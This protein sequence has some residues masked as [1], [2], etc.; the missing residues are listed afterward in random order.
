M[1]EYNIFSCATPNFFPFVNSVACSLKKYKK[2][3]CKYVYHIFLTTENV[4][5]YK[6][7]LNHLI[8]DDFEIKIKSTKG[9][10]EKIISPNQNLHWSTYFRCFV[11]SL[12]PNLDKILYLDVDLVIINKGLEDFM[13]VDLTNYYGA[14]I[15]DIVQMYKNKNQL[16][17]TKTNNYFNAGVL[18]FNLQKIRQEG[19]NKRMEDAVT[20]NWPFEEVQPSAYD[21][22]LLNYLFRDR[23]KLINPKFNNNFHCSLLEELEYFKIQYGKWG[24]SDLL[25]SLKDA[26][27]IHWAGVKPWWVDYFN[28][29]VSLMTVPQVTYFLFQYFIKN[30]Y[31]IN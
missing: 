8:S 11:C 12:F 17:N 30:K 25:D 27:I 29:R 23:V 2:E 18:L 5:E 7:K 22:S 13:D 3:N 14:A 20:G 28:Q 10:G 19:L 24:Y 4:E 26:V 15:L 9:Y 16:N 31:L 1:K 6:N 21:Q